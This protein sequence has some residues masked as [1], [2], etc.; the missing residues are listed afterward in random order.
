MFYLIEYKYVNELHMC[1]SFVDQKYS[2]AI[3]EMH[4]DNQEKSY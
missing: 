4:F 3:K 2:H 1:Q